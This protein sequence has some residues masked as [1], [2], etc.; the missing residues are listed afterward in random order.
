MDTVS[1]TSSTRALKQI[2][3]FEIEKLSQRIIMLRPGNESYEGNVMV[4]H[5]EAVFMVRKNILAK[6]M[7]F[8]KEAKELNSNYVLGMT[9]RTQK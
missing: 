3:A 1:D 2:E 8:W 7:A 5:G 9:E 6:A 4:Q